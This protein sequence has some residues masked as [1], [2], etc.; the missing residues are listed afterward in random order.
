MDST[1]VKFEVSQ[2]DKYNRPEV[3]LSISGR[4]DQ[5]QQAQD[6]FAEFVITVVEA[7]RKLERK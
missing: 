4:A 7:A 1:T 2:I 3:K 5:V 6:A